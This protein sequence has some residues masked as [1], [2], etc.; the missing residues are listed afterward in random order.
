MSCKCNCG[1][2][3]CLNSVDASQIGALQYVKGIDA[4]GCPKYQLASE[5]GGNTDVC[6]LIAALPSAGSVGAGQ[7]AVVVGANCQK[8]TINIPAIP[9][10]VDVC[11]TLA[12]TTPGPNAGNGVGV[13]VPGVTELIGKDC[14]CY[15]LPPVAEI[16]LQTAGYDDTTGLLA[17]QLTNGTTFN[18]PLAALEERFANGVNTTL[19]GA[20]T[21]GSP[22]TYNVSLAGAQAGVPNA[23]QSVGNQLYVPAS[24]APFVPTPCNLGAVIQPAANEYMTFP[25][26]TPVDF[27]VLD[28]AGCIKYQIPVIGTY[29]NATQYVPGVRIFDNLRIDGING[30]TATVGTGAVAGGRDTTKFEIGIDLAAAQPAGAN[31][32]TLVGGKL[33]VPPA[34]ATAFDPCTAGATISAVATTP[35]SM[36]SHDFVVQNPDGCLTN[37]TRCE[38]GLNLVNVVPFPTMNPVSFPG[39][40]NDQ[41]V[42]IDSVTGCMSTA[43]PFIYALRN[44]ATPAAIY[45][46]ESFDLTGI[47][48]VS[49][50]PV[51]Q[52][53]VFGINIAPTQGVTPN[54]LQVIGAGATA[55]LYVP[56]SAAA[57]LQDACDTGAAVRGQTTVNAP[58]QLVALDIN[59]CLAP[60]AQPAFAVAYGDADGSGKIAEDRNQFFWIPGQ[61]VLGVGTGTNAATRHVVGPSAVDS[62]LTGTLLKEN[63]GGRNILFGYDVEALTTTLAGSIIGGA[64]VKAQTGGVS[65]I[66]GFNLFVDGNANYVGGEYH[67]VK[68][69]RNAVFSAGYTPAGY[70]AA[71]LANEY[72][73]DADNCLIGGKRNLVRLGVN[74]LRPEATFCFGTDNVSEDLLS[75]HVLGRELIGSAPNQITIGTQNAPQPVAP[76]NRSSI[77]TDDWVFIVGAGQSGS[78]KNALAVRYNGELQL[79]KPA[80][81]FGSL[82]AAGT[83]NLLPGAIAAYVN[84]AITSPAWFDGVVWK[85]FQLI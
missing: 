52:N 7:S 68:G 48:G 36:G 62:F 5:L 31:Q 26:A 1:S 17:L 13:A 54:A 78:R 3:P 33:Y 4:L 80:A 51:G 39:A 10:P 63:S 76:A 56:Q 45:L 65:S 18:V 49:V 85:Q 11:A 44:G 27:L 28:A 53:T 70:T 34:A 25:T 8:V 72:D 77:S 37:M 84:G 40:A 2:T 38:V 71:T 12:S 57:G 46:G 75:S 73:V 74:N 19:S 14:F 83:P 20:G 22:Y 50:T 60:F 81:N 32:A 64:F 79:L 67:R 47:G 35:I 66:I 16:H 69:S 43:E 42:T 29:A 9:A 24:A 55:A 41:I 82:P 21:L 15:T 30:L 58:A 23:L 6:A 61:N 59:D